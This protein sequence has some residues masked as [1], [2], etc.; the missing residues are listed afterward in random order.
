MDAPLHL[1]VLAAVRYLRKTGA[2]SVSVIGGSM[3]AGA[4]GDA[5]IASKPGEID[6]LVFLVARRTALPKAEVTHAIYRGTRRSSGDGPRSSRNPAE[7]RESS[8]AKNDDRFGWLRARSISLSD[9]SRRSVMREILQFLSA[10]CSESEL[11][12]RIGRIRPGAYQSFGYCRS[13]T[14]APAHFKSKAGGEKAPLRVI[15]PY[16]SVK[17][18]HDGVI[19]SSYTFLRNLTRNPFHEPFFSLAILLFA[20][21]ILL[22]M[23]FRLFSSGPRDKARVVIDTRKGKGMRWSILPWLKPWMFPDGRCSESCFR[24]NTQASSDIADIEGLDNGTGDWLAFTC[25]LRSKR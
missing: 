24:N 16:L 20:L 19:S 13:V 5:S 9:G 6:R 1:D 23:I 14:T 12:G 25:N 3:G 15:L 10:K 22:P 17:L 2:K 8:P 21:S 11:P 18:F 7:V 4:A